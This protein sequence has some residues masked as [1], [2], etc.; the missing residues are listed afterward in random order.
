MGEMQQKTR[1]MEK[2]LSEVQTL[3]SGMG[4]SMRETEK[5]YEEES[6]YCFFLLQFLSTE[7]S[8]FIGS[9]VLLSVIH[10]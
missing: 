10:M 7:N 5:L 8:V 4:K 9:A 6:R 1:Y 3:M 2:E